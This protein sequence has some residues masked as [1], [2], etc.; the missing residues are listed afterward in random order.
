[1][2][3]RLSAYRSV[4]ARDRRAWAPWLR[5]LGGCHGAYVVREVT[6]DG[7]VT[8]YVGESHSARLRDTL[9]R[10]FQLWRGYTA[11]VTFDRSRRALQVAVAITRTGAQ[12]VAK[13]SEL[14]SRLRPVQNRQGLPED[15]ATPF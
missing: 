8:L 2:T 9:Q 15:H 1:M 11:G 7:P 10:H 6:R 12:A 14:I 3:A 5:E 13:Q 4:L